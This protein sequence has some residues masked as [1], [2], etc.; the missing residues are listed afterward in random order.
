M[1]RS[2][3]SRD[4]RGRASW[5]RLKARRGDNLSVVVP[6]KALVHAH[7]S[8]APTISNSMEALKT[9][10]EGDRAGPLG[11][12]I[13]VP[14]AELRDD[15][16][17]PAKACF[18]V[19]VVLERYLAFEPGIETIEHSYFIRCERDGGGLGGRCIAGLEQLQGDDGS[20]G[21][22]GGELDQ[23]IGGLH[24]TVFKSQ[25]LLLQQPP[26]LL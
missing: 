11:G 8:E 5:W 3:S 14:A 10:L 20:L 1:R 12:W 17:G 18:G 23:T 25:A 24:L 15:P 16:G 9:I 2:S 19:G 26:E 6:A 13:T 4:F 7:I 21:R 22:D